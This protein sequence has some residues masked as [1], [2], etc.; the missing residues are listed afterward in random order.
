M[1]S[2]EQ[3]HESL[4]RLGLSPA[5]KDTARLLGLS[6]RQAQRIYHGHC[7]VPE[8]VALLLGAYLAQGIDTTSTRHTP[9]A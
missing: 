7:P 2:R 4:Q 5:A 6:V 1:M 9:P 3:Y 8:P